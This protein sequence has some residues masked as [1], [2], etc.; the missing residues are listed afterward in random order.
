MKILLSQNS[1]ALEF[2]GLGINQNVQSPEKELLAKL[3][4]IAYFNFLAIDD[5]VIEAISLNNH[6]LIPVYEKKNFNLEKGIN[7]NTD[8]PEEFYNAYETFFGNLHVAKK[9][10]TTFLELGYKSPSPELSKTKLR[11]VL[12]ISLQFLE[13]PEKS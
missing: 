10:N 7:L 5:G 8:I 13:K 3:E 6:K 12:E 11:K 4:S 2:L 1:Q 9:S